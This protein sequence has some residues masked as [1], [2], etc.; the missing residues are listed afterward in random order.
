MISF[1][2]MFNRDYIASHAV[3]GNLIP[4]FAVSPR[5]C[6]GT[7]DVGGVN[8]WL[9]IDLGQVTHVQFVKF[10]ARQDAGEYVLVL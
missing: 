2:A 8:S 4:D 1:G 10:T 7:D 6:S 5:S 9:A 3:D